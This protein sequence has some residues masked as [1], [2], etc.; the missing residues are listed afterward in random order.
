MEMVFVVLSWVVGH[1]VIWKN[2]GIMGGQAMDLAL[3][4]VAWHEDRAESW[5]VAMEL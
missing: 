3:R 4:E 5:N 2:N 1:K